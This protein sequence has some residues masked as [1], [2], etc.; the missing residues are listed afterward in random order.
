LTNRAGERSGR[1]SKGKGREVGKSGYN[2]EGIYRNN[3]NVHYIISVLD[4]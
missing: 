4:E 1:E 2:N 3:S